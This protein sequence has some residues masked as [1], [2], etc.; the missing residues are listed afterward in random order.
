MP[1]T[2]HY[3]ARYHVR[4]VHEC[5]RVV[6]VL[7]GYGVQLGQG[8]YECNLT[9]FDRKRLLAHLSRLCLRTGHVHL[10]PP[11]PNVVKSRPGR[12]KIPC[13]QENKI[14]I[15]DQQASSLETI[16][17]YRLRFRLRNCRIAKQ[18]TYPGAIFQAILKGVHGITNRRKACDFFF[19]P[20]FCPWP[21]DVVLGD[22]YD[23]TVVFPLASRYQVE[24]FAD[25]LP[26][27][28]AR[29]QPRTFVLDGTLAVQR[30][31][32]A[33]VAADAALLLDAS[34]PH[35][36]LDFVTPVELPREISYS[37]KLLD[38]SMLMRLCAIHL[39]R[40]YVDLPWPMV[41]DTNDIGVN[42]ERV[43]P[44]TRGGRPIRIKSRSQGGLRIVRGHMG[45][46]KLSGSWQ[47]LMPLLLVCSELHTGYGKGD[48]HGFYAQRYTRRAIASFEGAYRLRTDST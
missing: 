28:L 40:L 36:F 14:R 45:S 30:R 37:P 41:F 9:S 19:G 31:N 15:S 17:W 29:N 38:A 20:T 8:V 43:A 16:S 39:A 44:A 3:L 12:A 33:K 10:D 34:A 25:A 26:L 22:A 48:E 21:D 35:V 4:D 13:Q 32:A 24:R 47:R 23:L 6:G 1:Q 2:V 27:Q 5:D 11:A 18:M 42:W 7:E 46:V